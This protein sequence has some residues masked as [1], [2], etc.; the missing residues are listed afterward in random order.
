MADARVT[1]IPVSNAALQAVETPYVAF[2]HAFKNRPSRLTRQADALDLDSAMAAYAI[3]DVWPMG[4]LKPY[5]VRRMQNFVR[6]FALF[7]PVFRTHLWP[8]TALYKTNV[9][10]HCVLN[11]KIV[12]RPA[13]EPWTR[14]KKDIGRSFSRRT[15]YMPEPMITVADRMCYSHTFAGPDLTLPGASCAVSILIVLDGAIP[16]LIAVTDVFKQS[17]ADIEVLVADCDGQAG[18]LADVTEARLTVVDTAGMTR[19]AAMNHL[20]E[21]SHGKRIALWDT[22]CAYDPAR[23]EQ[24]MKID[25]DFVGG[26]VQGDDEAELHDSIPLG[27]TNFSGLSYVPQETMLISRK[28]FERLGGFD[29]YL[30]VQYALD[31]Q[32]RAFGDTDLTLAQHQAML[33]RRIPGNHCSEHAVYG[34]YRL[35]VKRDLTLAH[36]VRDSSHRWVSFKDVRR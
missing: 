36:F 10:K 20:L 34:L 14:L 21:L 18:K 28:A 17:L 6:S 33:A 5:S 9:L 24:Q 32:L 29:P 27:H 35:F 15:L 12:Y 7:K 13:A 23:L 3:G 16:D 31:I 8:E 1:V 19:A 2:E 30:S 4:Q 11:E 25:A 26:P 22:S